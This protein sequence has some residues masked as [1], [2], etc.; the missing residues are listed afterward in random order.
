[1]KSHRL[2]S[3]GGSVRIASGAAMLLS[4]AGLLRA[5]GPGQ[6]LSGRVWGVV[7]VPAL[8]EASG[9]SCGWVQEGVVW[10]HNDG[11]REVLHALDAGG[12]PMA[13]FTFAEAVG[14]F[15]ELA[16]GPGI[17]TLV[18]SGAMPLRGTCG[19]R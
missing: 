13:D 1:M 10:T 19:A 5:Q 9:I 3:N 4:L 7:D 2:F 11:G 17:C 16:A 14:D 15:E 12:R 18:I 8:R 6:Y